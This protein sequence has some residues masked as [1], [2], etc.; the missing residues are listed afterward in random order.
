MVFND[1]TTKLGLLQDCEMKLFGDNGYGQ[2]TGNPNRLLQFTARINRRQDRFVHL[3]LIADGRWQ[4]D[5]NNNTDYPTATTNIV[6]GQSAYPLS[7]E[8][9]EI[10]KVA[11]K[12][13]EDGDYVIIYSTD[14]QDSNFLAKKYVENNSNNTGIPFAYDKKADSIVLTSTP[15]YNATAGI[16]IFYKRGSNNFVST[17]TTKVPGF[18]S[19]YHEYLSL[20]ASL[21]YA[22]D[23]NMDK[24]I[25]IFS[26]KILVME[27]SIIEYFS[28]R[29]KD[30]VK[31]IRA[32]NRSS[33]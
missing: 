19:I 2:I 8:M 30:E 31:I 3:A 28:R 17:D 32:V 29:N 1:T 16:K 12:Q 25:Q 33:R 20:G 4:N 23:R 10:E 7:L 13:K 18:A 26:Q 24:Q 5:D 27:D 6:S 9:I 21:D 22:I 11:I 15:N 14:I